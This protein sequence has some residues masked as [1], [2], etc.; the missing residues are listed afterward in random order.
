MLYDMRRDLQK[1]DVMEKCGCCQFAEFKRIEV[2]G[3]PHQE[4]EC[5]GREGMLAQRG[6]PISGLT[7]CHKNCGAFEGPGYGSDFTK[8]FGG[9]LAVDNPLLDQPGK[10]GGNCLFEVF[11]SNQGLAILFIQLWEG[12]RWASWR[13]SCRARA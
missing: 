10:Y 13:R 5:A 7:Q 9:L 6:V 1:S 8:S 4:S 3:L 12:F 11:A 2:E